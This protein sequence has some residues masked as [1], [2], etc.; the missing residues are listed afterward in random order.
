[1]TGGSSGFP[2]R[3]YTERGVWL[4]R[5][6]AYNKIMLEW[7]DCRL[8]DKSVY[9]D[10]YNEAWKHQIFGRILALSSFYMTDENLPIY[11]EKIRKFKPKYI[12]AYPSAP[13]VLA[14]YMNK[15]NIDSFPSIKSIISFGETL[16]DWHRDLL[17]N[18]FKCKVYNQYGHREQSVIAA[19]C[20]KSNYFHVFPQYGIVELI[21]KDGKPVTKEGE[22]GEIVATGFHTFIFPF[23]RLKTG[24]VAVHTTQKCDCGRNFSL[25]KNVEGRLQDFLVSKTKRIVPL[26]Q[27]HHLVGSTSMN[28]KES[29][30]Y[31]DTEGE[32][33]LNIVKTK[34]YT[35]RDTIN[36]KNRFQKILGNDFNITF[37]FVDHIPRTRRGKYQFLIQK[38]PIEF[39]PTLNSQL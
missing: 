32:V 33:V 30:L 28:V 25:L 38:L 16:Y 5:L 6:F 27:V 17:E 10:G 34:D 39:G 37:C 1:M 24:D 7:A 23:I 35:E 2:L 11:I 9:F 13:L 18:T 20:E 36:I 14:N 8:I 3:F 4:A 22:I 29:Q 31:Q 26:I 12:V 19:T 21:D 15:N